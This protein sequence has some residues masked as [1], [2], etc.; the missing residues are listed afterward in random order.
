[1]YVVNMAND[2][3]ISLNLLVSFIVDIL[4]IFKISAL[5]LLLFDGRCGISKLVFKLFFWREIVVSCADLGSGI[6]YL[7]SFKIILNLV[8]L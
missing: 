5:Q 7:K 8:D 3:V 2:I 1:M 4:K 6:F